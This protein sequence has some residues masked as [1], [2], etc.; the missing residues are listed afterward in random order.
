MFKFR[1]SRED[2]VA[3]TKPFTVVKKFFDGLKFVPVGLNA[4]DWV[5]AIVLDPD[6]NTLIVKQSRWGSED[7]TVEF[8]CGTVEK[9]ERPQLAALREL[10]E[11]TGFEP[12][13]EDTM[14]HFVS[15]NPN[16]AYFNNAMSVFIIFTKKHLNQLELKPSGLDPTEDCVP[17]VASIH[18]PDLIADLSKHAFG[19][20][21]VFALL[22]NHPVA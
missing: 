5:M 17:Y 20:I 3:K 7:E 11:E 9:G 18:S 14:R 1:K 22:R 19:L 8:P 21:G 12:D 16:P 15:V 4:P 13:D 10:K 2:V 6:F